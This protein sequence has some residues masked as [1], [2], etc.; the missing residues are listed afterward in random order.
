MALEDNEAIIRQYVE[1]VWNQ[2]KV[3]HADELVARDY[4]DHT[5]CPGRRP[6]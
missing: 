1:V 4:I 2:R 5:F 3:D 6:G